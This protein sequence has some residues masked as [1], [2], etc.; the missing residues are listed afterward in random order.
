[1]TK[2]ELVE[3]VKAHAV[4]NYEDDG[5]DYLVECYDDG[6]VAEL[7]DGATTVEEAIKAAAE[8]MRLLDDRR[9]D[10]QATAW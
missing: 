7:I 2:N 3:A 5:W 6:E 10:I 1:M 4:E 8:I 9:K